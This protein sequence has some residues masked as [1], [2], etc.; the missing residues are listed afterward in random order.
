MEAATAY[1]EEGKLKAL[2]QTDVVM[3]QFVS[4]ELLS[5]LRSL[6]RPLYF[7]L[8]AVGFVLL[9]SCANVANL[10]LGP[11]LVREREISLRASLG[12]SRLRLVRQFLTESILLALLGGLFGLALTVAGIRFFRIR[13]DVVS[14]G[15]R[16]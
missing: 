9:I 8:G 4:R 16:H 10:L 11:A 12:A 7:M 13:T 1:G 14:S 5:P 2:D 3:A 6:R 15:K